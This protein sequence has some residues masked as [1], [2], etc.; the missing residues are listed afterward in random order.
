MDPSPNDEK[1]LVRKLYPELSEQELG[2]ALENLRGYFAIAAEICAEDS[3]AAVST[4][5]DSGAA[6]PNMNERS[7]VSSKT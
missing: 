6:F 4:E 5:V 2:E 7:N 1:E 3:R